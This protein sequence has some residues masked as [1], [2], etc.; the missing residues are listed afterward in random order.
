MSQHCTSQ[1]KNRTYP[2]IAAWFTEHNMYEK[3]RLS[4]ILNIIKY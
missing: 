2:A 4:A 3:S 1:W